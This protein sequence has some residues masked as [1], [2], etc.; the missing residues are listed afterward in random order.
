MKKSLG[1]TLPWF[2]SPFFLADVTPNISRMRATEKEEEK[3]TVD[4]LWQTPPIQIFYWTFL[5]CQQR[6]WPFLWKLFFSF[7]RRIL[8]Y[9][10]FWPNH[11]FD[12]IHKWCNEGPTELTSGRRKENEK[13]FTEKRVLGRWF[14]QNAGYKTVKNAKKNLFFGGSV[15]EL[16][17]SLAPAVRSL[18][19]DQDQIQSFQNFPSVGLIITPRL[20][21]QCK[22][23]S[24]KIF[25]A[26]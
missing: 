26:W 25:L 13:L 12:Y 4:Y 21:K 23:L 14:K 15:Q 3:L 22:I 24:K 18:A 10:R 17:A 11:N 7:R 8:Q 16:W 1:L 2:F 20:K 19:A 9:D 5:L 6:P